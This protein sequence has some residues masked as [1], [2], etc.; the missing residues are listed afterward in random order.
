M[1]DFSAIYAPETSFRLPPSAPSYSNHINGV[2]PS[3]IVCVLVWSVIW[4]WKAGS[5]F[6]KSW[7]NTKFP[8][9]QRNYPK[10][11]L[12]A[13]LAGFFD[14]NDNSDASVPEAIFRG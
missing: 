6:A 4:R 10:S 8:R 14:P 13:W 9:R 11:A 2:F 5:R 1:M 3:E 12:E 7:P